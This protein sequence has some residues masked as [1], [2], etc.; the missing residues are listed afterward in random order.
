MAIFD[1]MLYGNVLNVVFSEMILRGREG[2]K[3]ELYTHGYYTSHYKKRFFFFFLN[4]L[5][6][7]WKLWK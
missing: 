6:L 5:S 4:I 3:L 7:L 1:K 2:V